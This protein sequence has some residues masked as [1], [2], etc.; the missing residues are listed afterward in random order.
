MRRLIDYAK[1]R[2]ESIPELDDELINIKSTDY[3]Y[4]PADYDYLATVST[5]WG[6]Q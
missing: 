6:A 5:L 1:G 3:L 4:K 2:I